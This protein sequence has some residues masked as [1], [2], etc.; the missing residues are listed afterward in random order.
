MPINF[1][2]FIESLDN[3]ARFAWIPAGNGSEPIF[4]KGEYR[5]QYFYNTITDAHAYYCLD[6]DMFLD[7]AE[8]ERL[9][10]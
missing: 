6:T 10:A 5:Y 9:L 1:T 7:D 2:A 8:V 3:R 4:T